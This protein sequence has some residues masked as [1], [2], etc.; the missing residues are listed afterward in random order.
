MADPHRVLGTLLCLS[1]LAGCQTMP[2]RADTPTTA[3]SER[4]AASVP[5]VAVPPAAAENRIDR[6]KRHTTKR[7]EP[8]S[9]PAVQASAPPADLWQQMRDGFA[10]PGCG[11]APGSDGWARRYA[12]SPARFAATLADMLPALDYTHRRIQAARLPSEFALLPIIESHYRPYPGRTEAPAGIWQMVGGTARSA[13]LRVDTWF[14]GRL[15]LAASTEAAIALLDRYGDHFNGDWRL[16]AFAYNA[17]E[18]R[19]KRALA[20]HAAG[21]DFGSLRA[22]RLSDT[23]YEYLSKLLALAC[24][25]REPERF[26]MTLPTLDERHRLEPLAVDGAIGVSLAHALSGL[27]GDDFARFNGGFLRGR[28]PPGPASQRLLV[29]ASVRERAERALAMIPA[30]RRLDWHQRRIGSADSLADLA[31]RSGVPI[32]ALYA[33]N[34]NAA[35][36]PPDTGSLVWLPRDGS[37]RDR[38]RDEPAADGVYVVR[39]GDSLW[40]IARRH[41]LTVT[42]LLRYNRLDHTRLKPGQRLLLAPQ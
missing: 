25:V 4:P 27:S 6:P 17:G 36:A 7:T 41:G 33:L 29:A 1:L 16:A 18:Y 3:E 22:L 8:A 13:G 26:G 24:L 34:G 9:A 20:R 37:A 23:S 32:D 14:D 15:N 28:T 2:R 19:L 42:E 10:L 11:Y 40:A 39:N 12:A 5:D 31:V 30:A 21:P 38:S 35:D